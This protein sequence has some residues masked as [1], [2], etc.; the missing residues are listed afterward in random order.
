M[1]K[2]FFFAVII[3]VAVSATAQKQNFRKGDVFLNA[4]LSELR[5]DHLN[6]RIDSMRTVN[7]ELAVDAGYFISDK[8]AVNAALGYG[9]QKSG[10]KGVEN[11]DDG[12]SRFT[13]GAGVRYYPVGNL[14]AGVGYYGGKSN[15][16][17]LYSRLRVTAGYDL[18]LTGS[19]FFEPAI[20]YARN[21]SKLGTDNL[22]LSL[23]FGVK[24]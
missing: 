4:G 18:F 17:R 3:S 5:F 15:G 22:G 6:R 21:L 2:I 11:L 7:I 13:F 9:Y 8:F 19:V 14:F 10:K 12:T 1:K 24:F 20:Y 16:A 23:A